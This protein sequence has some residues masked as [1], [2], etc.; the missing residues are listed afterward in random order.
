MKPFNITY[1]GRLY[2]VTNE[3]ELLMLLAQLRIADQY[4]A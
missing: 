3:P 2:T 1:H 4:A